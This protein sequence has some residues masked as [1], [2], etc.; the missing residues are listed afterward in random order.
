M[1][2]NE[3]QQQQQQQQQFLTDA[4][5][6]IAIDSFDSGPPEIKIPTMHAPVHERED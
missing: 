4:K 5:K 2:D 1:E 6:A 3:Q